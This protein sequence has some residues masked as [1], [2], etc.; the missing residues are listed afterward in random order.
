MKGAIVTTFHRALAYTI[1]VLHPY[2]AGRSLL[3][4]GRGVFLLVTGIQNW[5]SANDRSHLLVANPT[6][7][8]RITRKRAWAAGCAG[9]ADAG[10]LLASWH[11]IPFLGIPWLPTGIWAWVASHLIVFFMLGRQEPVMQ[12]IQT[13]WI[14]GEALIRKIVNDITATAE[15]KK[16]DETATILQPV[17]QL[18]TGKGYDVVIRVADHANA[19]KLTDA[20]TMITRKLHKAKGT[21]IVSVRE[22]DLSS[23]RILVLDEDPWSAPATV[24]PLVASPRPV[25]LWTEDVDLGTRPDATAFTRRL[26]IKGDGGGFIC[27]GAPGAGKS[28]LI[29]NVLVPIMLDVGSRLHIIDGKA[30]DFE[31]LRQVAETYIGDPDLEDHAIL[32][33]ATK[34]LQELKKEITRRRKLL[35]P[36]KKAHIDP[37]ICREY[38]LTVEWLVIDELAVLTEDLMAT[39]KKEVE[40][41]RE[42]LQYI[43]RMGRAFGILCIFATQRPSDK[44]IP[45]AIRDLIIMRAALYI[46]SFSGSQAILG[47]AG[48]ANR[49]DKLNPDQKG[50]A[51][52]TRVGQVRMHLVELPDLERVALYAAQLRGGSTPDPDLDYPEPVRSILHVFHVEQA[53]KELPSW[54]IIRGLEALDQ[55]Y[56]FKSLAAALRVY[57]I[58]SSLIGPKRESGYQRA[59]LERVPKVRLHALTPF[60]VPLSEREP[61]GGREGD[62]E[63]GSPM[64]ANYGEDES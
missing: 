15:S 63:A 40:I 35:L 16:L 11:Y 48:L 46:G 26:L 42:L 27:G 28:V 5:V 41:F 56:S 50:V 34:L 53:D 33:E 57:G 9:F 47:K 64:A 10:A 22:S 59:A 52:F 37:A 54:A 36:L 20:A 24:H 7:H 1:S 12:R 4:I 31:P 45:V 2:T 61:D 55:D 44:S 62:G 43:V 32:A 8:D 58:E 17:R 14:A 29:G 13:P 51:I 3:A 6:K 21:V 30:V 39:H 49:A 25:N 60:S 23:Y 18:A 19:D 38:S